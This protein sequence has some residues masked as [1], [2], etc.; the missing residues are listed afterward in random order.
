MEYLRA[1]KRLNTAY[2]TLFFVGLAIV[3]GVSAYVFDSIY[4]EK[5]KAI[6]FF[7]LL[8]IAYWIIVYLV[9]R[10]RLKREYEN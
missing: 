9:E 3:S 1:L 7:D 10:G 5:W 4:I 6:L 8:F 2:I